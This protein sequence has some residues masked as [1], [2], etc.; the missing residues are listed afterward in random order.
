M[1]PAD[2]STILAR[3]DGSTLR[4]AGLETTFFRDGDRFLVR[5]DGPDGTPQEFEIRY[6]FGVRP[7]QQYLVEL[8]GGRLQALPFA[9][10]ARAGEER[11]YHLYPDDS[12]TVGD[13]LHWTGV[14]QNWNH[15][16]ADCHSTNLVKGYDAATRSF[17]TTWSDIDVSCEA[18]HGPG[19]RHV[20]WARRKARFPLLY[21]DGDSLTE[22]AIGL[23]V[24]IH[25]R[26]AWAWRMDPATGTARRTR[27][28]GTTQDLP[29]CARCHAR[30]ASLLPEYRFG[31]PFEDTHVLEPPVPPLYHADGQV[32]E[33]D[34]VYGSFLQS[35]MY[36]AGVSC[37]NCHDAHSLRTRA[38]G[39]LLCRTC[40]DP[41]RFDTTSHHGH[42]PGTPGSLCVDCHM[43]ETVYMGVD[44]RRDHSFTVPRPALS[45]AAGVPNACTGCHADRTDGWAIRALARL[46]QAPE[47]PPFAL[48]FHAARTGAPDAEARLLAVAV[49][50]AEAAVRRA[51]ALRLLR[52]V[53]GRRTVPVVQGAL[54][55]R[56]PALRWAALGLLELF[57]PSERARLGAPLLDD[58]ARS[59]RIE[60]AR[61]LADPTARW[62][63]QA[64]DGPAFDR[65]LAEYLDVL[66]MDADRPEAQ[67]NLGLVLAAQGD[68]AG[69]EGA[70]REAIR[71]SPWY[72]QA[73]VN[74][75]DL[76]RA[77]GRDA[78]GEVLLRD[79]LE[80][81]PDSA[82][83]RHALGLLLV[84]A[85]RTDEALPE[86]GEAA[87]LRPDE[88]RFGYVHAVALHA[89]GR[90]REALERIDALLER[91]PADA[92]LLYLLATVRRDRGETELAL[93]AARRLA[94]A[95]P[96]D[97]RGPALVDR[98]TR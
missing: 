2:E 24:S 7:L 22:A 53:A 47:V 50:T 81:Q 41:A 46:G 59:V 98:L 13:P 66:R 64:A 31:L 78:E 71:L 35:R 69:A 73:I 61:V 5:T 40:H 39:N 67:A 65:A 90:E 58:P 21:P 56:E 93:E 1:Q 8:P 76:Y 44:A 60:A 88:I 12:L 26:E 52:S 28:R 17:A 23:V 48:A 83:L 43:P 32:L 89:S 11:W 37:G 75:A 36:R 33:E 51:G 97:P 10:G 68:P 6:A 29:T 18:C 3:F 77:A 95:H 82:D 70:F 94:Q 16:C 38:P 15:Q 55:S 14:F 74:L 57:P 85:R 27:P 63:L 19:S 4:H 96:D 42:V 79:A 34:Y 72:A 54:T 91:R 87:R 84:R 62:D 25:D 92:Q 49:D 9:W 30:R 20:A 80:R 45:R 86:L